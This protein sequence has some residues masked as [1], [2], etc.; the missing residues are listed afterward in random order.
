MEAALEPPRLEHQQPVLRA[1]GLQKSYG[2][3][4]ALAQVSLALYPGEVLGVVGESGSGKST[5]LRLLN[6]Q[7][8]P[9]GGDYRLEVPGYAGQ[10]LFA[11][12]RYQARQV[13]VR[14]IGI[15]YQNPHQGLRMQHTASG[16]VAERLILAGERRFGW[17]RRAA[18]E[19]LQA[20]EFP[21]ERLDEAP[22]RLSGGMQQRV[23]LAKALALQPTLLLLDEP[24]TGLDVSVQA[25]VLDTL[26]RLQRERG[27][28]MLIVSHDLGVIRTLADRVLVMRA[29][30]VVEQGLTDQV[31]EDP[32]HPY[33]QQ[34]VHA[35]L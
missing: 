24:T 3:V 19:A 13:R 34:L 23:Q 26:K 15:V 35:K 25:L 9:D 4:T 6:L 33:T 29:G 11:L 31:L 20:S 7:E 28:S 17:L 12:D 21:L 22:L 10:N 8:P 14:H 5:L 30:R 32:Q 2:R 1:M 18:R 27:I 16:N